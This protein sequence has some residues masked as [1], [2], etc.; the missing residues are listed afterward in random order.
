MKRFKDIFAEIVSR[1]L[2]PVWEIPLAILLAVAFAAT[3]GLR[4]RFLGLL[5]FID[6]VVP[7]IFFL[8]MLL[9]KQ[10]KDWDIQKRQQ[11]IPLYTFTLICHLAGLWLAHELG[12]TELVS[13]LG[14]FYVVGIIF[15]LI[16][17]KWKISLHGGVNAVLVTAINMFYGW[18][19][20]WLYGLLALVMW[21][22][23]YQ[24]HHSWAQVTAGAVLGGGLV[25][26]GLSMI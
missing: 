15:T 21:A 16:T 14:V 11:R 24:R 10:I 1:V 6:A 19:Y 7:M 13:V 23:V 4:W 18:Q 9:N 12:K 25:G 26:L 20:L 2:D 5:L 17:L 3:E 22:R 8:I